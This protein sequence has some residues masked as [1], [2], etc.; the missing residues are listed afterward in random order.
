MLGRQEQVGHLEPLR[1]HSP[2]Q[3]RALEGF[4]QG[5]TSVPSLIYATTVS[6][7]DV[8]VFSELTVRRGVSRL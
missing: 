5:V 3:C 4:H 6:V 2:G 7:H 8:P 1:L